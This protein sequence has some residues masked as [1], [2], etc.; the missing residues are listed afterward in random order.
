MAQWLMMCRAVYIH[1]FNLQ[2]GSPYGTSTC[3]KIAYETPSR[4]HLFVNGMAVT[5]SRA[6][7]RMSVRRR[8]P[9]IGLVRNVVVWYVKTGGSVS[10]LWSGSNHLLLTRLVQ[11]LEVS[12][13]DGGVLIKGSPDAA[14]LDEFRM[15][16]SSYDGGTGTPELI[17]FDTRIPQDHP[18]CFR[19]FGLPPR[20]HHH[21]PHITI[22]GDMPLPAVTRDGPV[23]VDPTQAVIVVE[24][25]RPTAADR[26]D[27]L[28][29]RAHSL[30][31]CRF[32]AC[33]DSF[34]P[35]EDW[36]EGS[37]TME[38][39]LRLTMVSTFVHG[40]HV[41]VAVLFASGNVPAHG[42]YTFDLSKRDCHASPLWSEGSGVGERRCGLEDGRKLVFERGKGMDLQGMR[43][44]GNGIMVYLDSVR[45]HRR[46]SENDVVG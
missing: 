16:V 27:F 46:S 39:P 1:L 6:M 2:D 40:T 5:R 33:T 30:I 26:R 34:I 10:T 15:V 41:V 31:G 44:L 4:A 43:F 35:W 36:G 21:S 9:G 42:L 7:M 25:G 20:Y 8:G 38:I 17:V 11:V 32:P 22:D 19:R 24:L 23:S 18:G 14:F 37:V 45:Y 12:T 13:G 3:N 28:I 29:V